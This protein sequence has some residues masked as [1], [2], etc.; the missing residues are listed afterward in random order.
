MYR[1]INL[2]KKNGTPKSSLS[3]FSQVKG[4]HILIYFGGVPRVQTKCLP[5]LWDVHPFDITAGGH[6]LT[7]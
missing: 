3:P 1:G 6:E 5:V 7:T 2:S 4:L